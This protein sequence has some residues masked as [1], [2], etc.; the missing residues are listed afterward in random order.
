MQSV[1]SHTLPIS[2]RSSQKCIIASL[3]KQYSNL[4]IIGEEGQLDLTNVTK[5]FIVESQNEEFLSNHKCPESLQSIKEEDVVV[6]LDPLDGT[7]EFIK[8]HLEHVT[9][10]IGIAFQNSPVAGIIHQPY[11]KC[12]ESGKLGRNI[13]GVRGLGIGGCNTKKPEDGKFII[14]T[15]RSHSNES[16]QATLD[17][18][19]PSE[20]LRVG[21]CGYKVL[22]L[23]EG[24]AHC[25]VFASNGCKKWE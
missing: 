10:L 11:F 23:L 5:D 2:S 9:V 14:T 24:S 4:K 17:A 13:W 12:P 22:Q 15:T 19:N 21:G 18:I 16:V 25:Y 8:G 6:W 3:T 7:S 1:T 20:V